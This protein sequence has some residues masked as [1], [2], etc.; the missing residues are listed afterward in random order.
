[1][2]DVLDVYHRPYDPRFPQICM[3]EG[4]KQLLDEIQDP[5]PVE[6]GKPRREDYEY[7]R[8]G[9]FNIFAACEP[10]TGKY[11]FASRRVEQKKIGPILCVILLMSS[12]KMQ[13]RSS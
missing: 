3:D 6:S 11:F 8:N 2:E 9:T 13:R 12:I 1:M 10:L 7:E 4:N 5:I